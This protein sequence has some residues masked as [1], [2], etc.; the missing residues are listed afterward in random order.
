MKC[1]E[2][3]YRADTTKKKINKRKNTLKQFRNMREDF[4]RKVKI[5]KSKLKELKVN[6]V[7]K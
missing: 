2:K 4:N 5:T 7:M 3:S 1:K 6:I